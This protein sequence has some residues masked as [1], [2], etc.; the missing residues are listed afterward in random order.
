V[1]VRLLLF[2]VFLVV[3]LLELWGL[4]RVGQWIG[5]WPTVAL[6]LATGLVGVS[7]A[8]AQGWRIWR[9][10]QEKLAYGE[11]PG[12]ELLDGLAVF[13]G[14]V[15]L[16][17]PGFFHRC[18]WARLPAAPEPG[19]HQA[20]G[21]AAAV[22]PAGARDARGVVEAP[23]VVGARDTERTAH[24][25]RRSAPEGQ[26]GT[27]AKT[28]ED[29]HRPPAFFSYPRDVGPQVAEHARPLEGTQDD[30]EGRSRDEADKSP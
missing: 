18:A 14:G 26:G 12:D 5:A 24:A 30:N 9:R 8:R 7:L 20:Q 19:A 29:A 10:A 6:V 2:L 25:H 17:M 13:V 16:L 11:L 23:M 28:R 15:L 3:P 22:A 21:Q 1:L 27:Q 4:I